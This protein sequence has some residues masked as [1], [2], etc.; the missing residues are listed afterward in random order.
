MAPTTKPKREETALVPDGQIDE[1]FARL[2]R[3]RTPATEDEELALLEAAEIALRSGRDDDVSRLETRELARALLREAR[4]EIEQP[5]SVPLRGPGAAAAAWILVRLRGRRA[6]SAIRKRWLGA[7]GGGAMAGLVGGFLGG[8]VLLYGPGSTA[9]GSVLVALPLVGVSV[10]SDRRPGSGRRALVGRGPRALAAR[11]RACRTRE[12][13]GGLVGGLAHFLGLYVVEGL[14]GRDL[15]PVGGGFEGLI[16]G[17]AV[18]IGYALAT[19]MREGGMAAPRGIA[20]LRAAAFAG[21][22]AAVAGMALALTGHHLGAM[23]LDFMARSFPGSQVS[24]DPL[25]HLLGET[26]AGAVTRGVISGFEGLG[27]GLGVVGG[28]TRRSRER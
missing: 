25:A 11:A 1:A 5:T 21:F 18:G 6:W 27:F 9:T 2:A 4:W 14:F 7:V 10:G 23:S 3:A 16:L 13:W 15:S 8:L 26:H 20:R 17:G 22:L 28:M 12:R 19:P 24:L